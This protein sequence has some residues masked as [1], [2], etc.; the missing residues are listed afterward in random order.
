M[1]RVRHVLARGLAPHLDFFFLWTYPSQWCSLFISTKS[2]EESL[3]QLT[4]TASTPRIT[5]GDCP[6]QLPSGRAVTA[7]RELQEGTTNHLGST[8]NAFQAYENHQFWP[9]WNYTSRLLETE[10]VACAQC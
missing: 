5:T 9:S 8:G 4:S 10:R 6:R 7:S 3:I 2:W 1:T